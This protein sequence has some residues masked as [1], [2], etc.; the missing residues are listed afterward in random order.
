MHQSTSMVALIYVCICIF[1]PTPNTSQ[2]NSSKCIRA[3]FKKWID[4]MNYTI[5][6][7]R[8][9]RTGTKKKKRTKIGYVR[10]STTR[11]RKIRE[12]WKAFKSVLSTFCPNKHVGI[13]LWR[14]TIEILKQSAANNKYLRIKQPT[15]CI[16]YPTFVIKL[17]MFRVSSVPII[18]S[19][20]MYAPQ[21]VRFLQ[22]M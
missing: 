20:L 3:L 1:T 2:F 4:T 7:F 5:S 19:Y 14:V 22:A 12:L 9:W 15:R 11:K 10:W 8:I 13:Q 16:E 21:L 6:K 18:R 17:Y